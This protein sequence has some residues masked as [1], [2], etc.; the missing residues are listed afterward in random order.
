MDSRILLCTEPMR[1]ELRLKRASFCCHGE[2]GKG[3]VARW[4]PEAMATHT[5]AIARQKEQI[6]FLEISGLPVRVRL[7]A[8]EGEIAAPDVGLLRFAANNMEAGR[9]DSVLADA[10]SVRSRAGGRMK[11]AQGQFKW[12]KT[13]HRSKRVSADL[14][15]SSGLRKA[16]SHVTE[17][18]PKT[19]VEN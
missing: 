11:E 1:R 3:E 2:K 15:W 9:I 7:R 18:Y 12:C 14:V 13:A 19:G 10:I 5:R 16:T 4:Y 8:W 6:L 17:R